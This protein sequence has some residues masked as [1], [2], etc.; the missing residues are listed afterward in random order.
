MKNTITAINE[1]RDQ[2]I[3]LIDTNRTISVNELA[4]I[5]N[6]TSV[7]IRKAS[8]CTGSGGK[9]R[10][11]LRRREKIYDPPAVDGTAAS[12]LSITRQRALARAAADLIKKDEVVL[13]NSSTTASYVVEYID[14]L[15]VT[16][17]SNNA[18]LLS[19]NI[20]PNT[21]LL[22][23]GGQILPGRSSL[24][25][26]YA[27]DILRRNYASKCIIGVRGISFSGGV[28]SPLLEESIIN[29]AMIEQTTGSVIIIAA[30]Y[31]IGREDSFHICGLDKVDIL[32]TDSHIRDKDRITIENMG[33]R[34][35]TVPYK[36][37]LS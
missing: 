14:D 9:N 1:R 2:I 36:A 23:T 19:R 8:G 28:T 24:S 37:E 35:I 16:I 26:P 27:V 10:T 33:I 22:M 32:V 31:K 17:I 6:V 3:S 5:L 13:I 20:N 29:Q 4:K 12:N 21:I 7:T 25:G 11:H 18:R 30:S 15:P 34:V